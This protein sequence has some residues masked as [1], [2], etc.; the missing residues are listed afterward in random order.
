MAGQVQA[1]G[2]LHLDIHDPRGLPGS[3]RPRARLPSE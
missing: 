1:G 3:G 2:R